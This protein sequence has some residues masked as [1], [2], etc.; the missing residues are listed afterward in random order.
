MTTKC[1]IRNKP[2]LIDLPFEEIRKALSLELG[3]IHRLEISKKL[4]NDECFSVL[5]FSIANTVFEKVNETR[6]FPI[7]NGL[8]SI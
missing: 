8:N 1:F 2:E 5:T 4:R 6:I 3:V 7:I